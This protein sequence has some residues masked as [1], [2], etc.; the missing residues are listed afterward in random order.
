[1]KCPGFSLDLTIY[2]RSAVKVIFPLIAGLGTGGLFFPP[3]ILMQAAM[4]V[5]DMA[6]STATLGLIRQLGCTVGVSIGQAIWSTVSLSPPPPVR[7]ADGA[8]APTQKL[9]A[10]LA[11]IPGVTLSTS[12]A[13]LADSIRQVNLIEV[14]PFYTLPCTHPSDRPPQPL[15]LRRQVQHAYTK[16]IATIWVVDTPLVGAS[17]LLGA[18]SP[19]ADNNRNAR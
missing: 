6:T 13:N 3:L 19:C 8:P 12:S 10:K 14:R 7:A 4:P 18:F 16:S 11:Q 1:M 9:R 17:F 2:S 5:K 15:A